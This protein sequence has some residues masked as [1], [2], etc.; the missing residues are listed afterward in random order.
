MKIMWHYEV[1]SWVAC[2]ALIYL[3][4][5]ASQLIV[6]LGLGGFWVKWICGGGLCGCDVR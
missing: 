1:M 3:D 2:G 4:E 5:L 6:L